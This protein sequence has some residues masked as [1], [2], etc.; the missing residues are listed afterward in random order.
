MIKRIVYDP[1]VYTPY[2]LLIDEDKYNRN[3]V[4]K[5]VRNSLDKSDT[6]IFDEMFS[7]IHM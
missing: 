5:T 4:Y 7:P 1:S 3:S 2:D 6:K